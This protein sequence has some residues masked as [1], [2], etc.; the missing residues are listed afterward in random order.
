MLHRVNRIVFLALLALLGIAASCGTPRAAPLE[1]SVAPSRLP[2]AELPPVRRMVVFTWAYR[3]RDYSFR[4]EGVARVSPPDSARFDFFLNGGWGGGYAVLV[5][6]R[7]VTSGGDMVRKM[8]PPVPLLWA[9]LGRLELPA[10]SDTT[11]RVD[12]DTLRVDIGPE[13]TWR[14]TFVDDSLRKVELIDGDRIQEIVTR[15][16]GGAVR[17]EHT[18]SGRRLQIAVARVDTVEAHDADIWP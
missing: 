12:A 4:G 7:L 18:R 17:Y 6:D 15:A 11:A 8:L 5:G 13:P 10:G 3:D 16:A 14:S 1:G 9:A 2:R